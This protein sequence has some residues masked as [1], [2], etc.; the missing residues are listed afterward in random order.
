MAAN[1]TD[2]QRQC[3]ESTDKRLV[4]SA[5]AGTGK[6][7]TITQKI[8]WMMQHGQLD[9][10]D[11]V[12]AITFTK[13]AAG[14]IKARIRSTLRAAGL[15]SQAL[16]VDGA[17]ISTIHGMCSRILKAHALEAGVDPGFKIID[18]READKLLEQAVETSLAQAGKQDMREGLFYDFKANSPWS[19]DTSVSSIVSRL[20]CAAKSSPDGFDSI[21][22]GPAPASPADIAIGLS[23]RLE[24]SIELYEACDC[25][26]KKFQTGLLARQQLRESLQAVIAG[27]ATFASLGK[28]LDC[29]IHPMSAND[30]PD[31]VE[32][33]AD[34]VVAWKHACCELRAYRSYDLMQEALELSKNVKQAYDDLKAEEGWL[35]NDDLMVL[36]YKLLA[37]HPEIADEY[38]DQFKLL[39]VDEFQDTSQLQIDII[40]LIT[41]EDAQ[42]CTVGDAQQSIYGF[43]G[44]DVNVYDRF[45][46]ESGAEPVKLETNFRSHGGV[47]EFANR[48]FEQ[49]RV[50]GSRF[51]YLHEGRPH[52]KDR[53]YGIPRAQLI[54]IRGKK[55][56]AKNHPDGVNSTT[57]RQY[58]AAAIAREFSHYRENGCNPG[59]MVLLLGVMS[60]VDIYAN[61]LRAEGFEVVVAGGSGFW[62]SH[63][64]KLV[65]AMLGV[66]SNPHDTLCI[67]NLLTLGL[68]PTRDSALV[69]IV[70]PREGLKRRMDRG[71][72]AIDDESLP[73]LSLLAGLVD[74]ATERIGTQHISTIVSQMLSDSGYMDRLR[75]KG[76]QGTAACANLLK[77]IGFIEDFER[78]HAY[79]INRV[80]DAFIDMV[81]R[82]GKE[83]P[84][85]LMSGESE[86][87]R[88]MTIHASKGLEFPVVAVAEFEKGS[89]SS[90]F[91]CK[92]YRGKT[93]AIIQPR[94]SLSDFGKLKEAAS[95]YTK[96][97]EAPDIDDVGKI[98][99]RASFENCVCAFIAKEEL[100]EEKR[101]F[102]VA[103]TR[104]SEGI[105]VCAPYEN[106]G[107]GVSE[108]SIS[109]DVCTAF[110]GSA[111]DD[112]LEYPAESGMFS[113]GQGMTGRY[114]AYTL[115]T[116]VDTGDILCE[117]E[118]LRVADAPEDP[119]PASIPRN[120]P[121][122]DMVVER[123]SVAKAAGMFSYSS[124]APA[125][126]QRVFHTADD[127][128]DYMGALLLTDE[129]SATELGSAFHATAEFMA[130]SGM[131]GGHGQDA[132]GSG[133]VEKPASA[134]VNAIVS[135]F[136]L[137]QRQRA[138][139]LRALDCWCGCEVSKRAAQ[140]ANVQAE[141]PFCME[142]P[143]KG[144]LAE[145][146]C[147]DADS[148][149]PLFINGEIDLLC[150]DAGGTRA[151]VVDYKTGGSEGESDEE[152]HEKH[153]LQSMCYAYALLSSWALSVEMVF[154]RV[155]HI[156]ANG[157]PQTVPY[158]Y[159]RS[160]LPIIEKTIAGALMSATSA[161]EC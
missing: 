45:I 114:M 87:V 108:G 29:P 161:A 99:D 46:A 37:A 6:T 10:I 41:G 132:P 154:V 94:S 143:A 78:D 112:V 75:A 30:Y 42:L 55:R 57:R 39:M 63:E 95:Q 80:A 69:D 125:H 35:D 160:Q 15:H 19:T 120:M 61:A 50:F 158:S 2:A 49:P 43:R 59:D 147:D 117:G 13:K 56:H 85:V 8:C 84:G 76:S 33:F 14:E 1:Y 38:K 40:S 79:S 47:L 156:D 146:A 111:G 145:G 60:N 152:L 118:D 74:D 150:S 135:W 58:A 92:S 151:F 73:E 64:C 68:V 130:L 52:S 155:E 136:G 89:Q 93:F 7:F 123:R 16:L 66:L 17:W 54:S 138:R 141:V 159:D 119:V 11:Q 28:A 144:S 153:L 131:L 105:V 32:R 116:D 27:D 128:H 20:I 157:E 72:A 81:E 115:S 51:L 62:A 101:K 134:R 98:S 126:A 100:G 65:A 34:D 23:R 83:G 77:A 139:Y 31:I 102:Y 53:E 124:I 127:E 48:I 91:C 36:A 142:F 110:F 22:I 107:K 104:A 82:G 113:Y 44:A 12:L 103:L 90:A 88:I 106:S 21:Y 133:I 96:C 86:A 26:T 149:D 25:Q 121:R 5:A 109:E 70:C 122:N 18:E 140:Y 67:Y 97:L 3:I 129:D 148:N 9:G 24:E 71:F 4:V 137:S